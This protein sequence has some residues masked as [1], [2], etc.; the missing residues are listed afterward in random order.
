MAHRG[1]GSLEPRRRMG[2]FRPP[3]SDSRENCERPLRGRPAA[4]PASIL[5]CPLAEK[6][7]H[8]LS[9]Q[10]ES[11]LEMS[12]QCCFSSCELRE[13]QN[14]SYCTFGIWGQQYAE[15]SAIHDLCAVLDEKVVLFDYFEKKLYGKPFILVGTD[16]VG[17]K[18]W[19]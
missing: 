12:L 18:Q 17:L 13:H 11:C 1:C 5:S 14:I 9:A 4:R 15:D 16:F 2:V 19:C 8:Y 7:G 6:H 3:R 10:C